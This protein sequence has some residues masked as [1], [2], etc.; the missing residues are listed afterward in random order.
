MHIYLFVYL[1][2]LQRLRFDSTAIPLLFSHRP[3]T[4]EVF[5][6]SWDELSGSL[7]L[8]ERVLCYQSSCHNC[9]HFV[10]VFEFMIANIRPKGV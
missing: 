8:E 2:L 4:V 5:F 10:S 1:Q 3:A 9:F 6:I 7:L